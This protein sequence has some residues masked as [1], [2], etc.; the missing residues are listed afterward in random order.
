MINALYDSAKRYDIWT[1]EILDQYM[2]N[3]AT[4]PC[5]AY[6]TP[7]GRTDTLFKGHP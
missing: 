1:E 7:E 2:C 3:E 4:C 5:L 6:D